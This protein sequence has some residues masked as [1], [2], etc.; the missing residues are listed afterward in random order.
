MAEKQ[1]F[2]NK[3]ARIFPKLIKDFN[4]QIQEPIRTPSRTNKRKPTPTHIKL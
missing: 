2:E 3:I 1:I 4:F